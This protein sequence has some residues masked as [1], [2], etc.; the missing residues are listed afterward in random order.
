MR[1]VEPSTPE[2][3]R[4]Y[5]RLRWKI[6]RAPWGR[7]RGSERD[8]LDETALHLMAIDD[9]QSVA[10]VGR[11]HFNTIQE[12]QIRYMAVTVDVQRKGIG[13]LLL[14]ALEQQA[15]ALGARRIILDARETALGFYCRH[16]YT[17]TGPGRVLYDSIAHV[18]MNKSLG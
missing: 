12:A 3:F 2:D 7:P 14:A 18:K 6:L 11:L 5:Y 17:P 13:S 8:A 10:G 15:V 4:H 1:I 16:G 9:D